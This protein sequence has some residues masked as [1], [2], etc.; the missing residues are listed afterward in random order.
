M[1][2]PVE[3]VLG[4]ALEDEARGLCFLLE[5]GDERCGQGH[6]SNSCSGR[7]LEKRDRQSSSASSCVRQPVQPLVCSSRSASD[8][9]R[10]W[11]RVS[12]VP[13]FLDIS[14]TVTSVSTI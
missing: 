8:W 2:T 3:L 9:K 13:S 6:G 11:V 4:D 7:R 14:S 10:V 1:R 5:L 12:S